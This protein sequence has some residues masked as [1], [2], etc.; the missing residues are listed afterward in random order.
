MIY[1]FSIKTKNYIIL[2]IIIIL[3]VWW[4]FWWWYYDDDDCKNKKNKKKNKNRFLKMIFWSKEITIKQEF[5]KDENKY[6][7]INLFL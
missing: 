7:H 3:K 5:K 4:Y 6:R 2:N 1:I